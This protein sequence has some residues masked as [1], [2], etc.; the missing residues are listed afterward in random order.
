MGA[1]TP[2]WPGDT[3]FSCGWSWEMATGASV[4]VGV[5]TTSLHVGTHADAPLHVLQGAPA[6]ESLP[7]EAFSGPA[8]VLDA[9]D[10]GEGPTL[11]VAWLEAALEGL[12]MPVRLLLRTGRTVA[13][14]TFPADWPVLTP[15]AT[16]WLLHGGLKLLGVDAPSVDSREAK[17]LVTHVRLFTS[18]AYLLENL[19]LDGVETGL[20]H[21]TAY[22]VL[23]AGAD[24]APVR[25][26]LEAA[27]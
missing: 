1:A 6:S 3:P 11:T 27:R 18:G 16:G 9:Q 19:H 23:V 25:A 4:N 10:A 5:V 17:E 14:G 2:E 15:E 26:V 20:Y 7:L 13:G 24:A 12:P 21:L 8:I 22:P